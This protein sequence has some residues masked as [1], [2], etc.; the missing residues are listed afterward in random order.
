MTALLPIVCIQ[1]F[2]HSLI[3]LSAGIQQMVRRSR[4]QRRDVYPDTESGFPDVVFIT[5]SA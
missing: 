3:A 1:V 5:S 4:R 2:E